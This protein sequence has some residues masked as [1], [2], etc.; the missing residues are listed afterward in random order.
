M[1]ASTVISPRCGTRTPFIYKRE[2]QTNRQNSIITLLNKGATNVTVTQFLTMPGL[3]PLTFKLSTRF[4]TNLPYACLY[5]RLT[6]SSDAISMSMYPHVL[7][8]CICILS[9]IQ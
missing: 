6:A 7:N 9:T 1:L 4:L 5:A 8:K 2:L 3:E